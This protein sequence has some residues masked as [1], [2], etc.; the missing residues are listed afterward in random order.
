VV[1]CSKPSC[2]Q[3]GTFVLAYD[4]ASKCA[5]IEERDAN[6]EMSPHLYALCMSCA[7]RLVP[8]RGWELVDRRGAETRED[9][10]TLSRRT[11]SEDELDPSVIAFGHGA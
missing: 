10:T 11:S 7:D 4:Y 1:R 3:S 9:I 8:P 2:K 6:V 5:F